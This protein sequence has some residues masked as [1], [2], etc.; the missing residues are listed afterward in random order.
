MYVSE[1]ASACILHVEKHLPA[2]LKLHSSHHVFIFLSLSLHQTRSGFQAAQA[3][4]RPGDLDVSLTGCVH[5]CDR[6]LKARELFACKAV[7]H[8]F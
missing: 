1:R 2:T 3:H 7:V 8:V 6:L 4:F 5:V